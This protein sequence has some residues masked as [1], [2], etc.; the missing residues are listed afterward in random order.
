MYQRQTFSF[1]SFF[2]LELEPVIVIIVIVM[3]LA[4]F[5]LSLSDSLTIHKMVEIIF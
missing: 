2:S 4:T 3:N 5:E 1:S